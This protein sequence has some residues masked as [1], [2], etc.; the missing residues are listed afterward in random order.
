[1]SLPKTFVKGF[2]DEN[3]V[4][5]MEYLPL[6]KTGLKVSKVSLGGGTFSGT[7]YGEIE[8]SEAIETVHKAVKSG[9]NYI[10]TAP[11]YGEGRSEELLGKA[12]KGVPRESY[13]LATKVGRYTRDFPT[14]FD[15]SAKKTRESLEKSLK[16]LGLDYVDVIQ[17][18]DIEFPETFDVVLN[19]C[20]PELEKLRKEGKVRFIGVSAYPMEPL[21]RIIQEVPGRF[22]IVLCYSRYTLLD[23]SLKDYLPFFLEQKLGVICAAGHALGL[24]TNKEPQ[25]W[26]PASEEIKSICRKAANICKN[27]NIDL[28]KLAMY[29]CMQ[30]EGPSTFL[31]GMEN[32]KLLDINLKSYYEGLTKTEEEVLKQLKETVFTKSLNWEGIELERYRAAMKKIAQS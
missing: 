10:D 4:A 25:P 1:M 21:K 11:F 6:G 17:I 2:H 13:Y 29:Y 5:K 26:H 22:D 7:F 19:E 3:L 30:L 20:L 16:L 8:L 9:I 23:K 31:T 15:Y 18:H 27:A 24:L 28:G 12:L 14:M 32:R